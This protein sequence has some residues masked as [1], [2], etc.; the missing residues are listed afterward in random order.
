MTKELGF[1]AATLILAG[2]AFAAD[3]AVKA[4]ALAGPLPAQWSGFYLGIHGGYGWG[5]DNVA[6]DISPFSNP[7]PRGGVFGGQAGYNWQYGS[8]VG[9]L[10]VDF[11]GADLRHSQSIT[12]TAVI[13]GALVSETVTVSSK[14]DYFGSARARAGFLLTPDWLFYGTAGFGWAHDSATG[15]ATLSINGT[16]VDSFSNTFFND[17]FGWTAGGGVEYRLWQNLLLRAE[18]L[19]YGFGSATYPNLIRGA[20]PVNYELSIDVVRGGLSYKF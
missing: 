13:G 20:V 8:I 3:L 19:H 10:E 12:G 15:S 5:H 7:S 4:P 6:G 16:V 17:H 14:V 2:P 11:S 1:V 9:G 18:Y